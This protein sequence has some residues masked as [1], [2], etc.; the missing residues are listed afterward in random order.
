M[1]RNRM[2]T[3]AELRRF[4]IERDRLLTDIELRSFRAEHAADIASMKKSGRLFGATDEVTAPLRWAR[5]EAELSDYQE[6]F[7]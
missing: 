7:S 2:L 4:R 5:V 1:P 6:R 3:D